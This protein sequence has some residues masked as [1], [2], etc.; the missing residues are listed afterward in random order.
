MNHTAHESLGWRT[1]IEWLLGHTADISVLLEFI[2]WQPVYYLLYENGDD[3][4]EERLGR[5]VGISE[6]VGH[7]MTFK[8]LSESNLIMHR[9]SV[10][11][12]MKGGV[13]HN[14]HANR[15]S[16]NLAPKTP[17]VETVKESDEG[18]EDEPTEA[19]RNEIIPEIV[20]SAFE[21]D[22][23]HGRPLPTIDIEDIV[24][25][26]FIT[27]PDAKDH[28]HRATIYDVVDLGWF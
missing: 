1:P 4:P 21:D 22:L 23:K 19:I 14:I 2:F 11:S 9:A 20:T 18:D 5:F 17:V 10:R 26:T 6:S 25:R 7:S 16:P 8:I 3:N 27:M 24:G 12:A 15:K 28:Q 13:F